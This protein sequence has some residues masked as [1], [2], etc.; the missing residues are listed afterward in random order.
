[1]IGEA[2]CR[3]EQIKRVEALLQEQFSREQA[4]ILDVARKSVSTADRSERSC[5]QLAER[6]GER[7]TELQKQ[8]EALQ[9]QLSDLRARIEELG[10]EG[11]EAV[12]GEAEA[13]ARHISRVENICAELSAKFPER[14]AEIQKLCALVGALQESSSALHTQLDGV[15]SDPEAKTSESVRELQE[16]IDAHWTEWVAE[17]TKQEDALREEVRARKA[18]GQRIEQLRADLA[19]RLSESERAVAADDQRV[20]VGELQSRVAELQM[21]LQGLSEQLGASVDS[22]E[23][24]LH[25]MAQA[26]AEHGEHVGAV[27]ANLSAKAEACESNIERL[28][29]VV[30]EMQGQVEDLTSQL[31]V[32]P[33][34]IEELANSSKEGLLGE[35]R[36]RV[37]FIRRAEMTHAQLSA[38]ADKCDNDVAGVHSLVGELQGHVE[39]LRAQFVDIPPRWDVFAD[40]SRKALQGEAQ[41]RSDDVHRIEEAAHKEV[42]AREELRQRMEEA[43]TWLSDKYSEC[44]VELQAQLRDLRGQVEA[45]T[46]SS[47]EALRGVFEVRAENARHTDAISAQLHGKA[48]DRDENAERL[49]FI[50]EELQRNVEH[51]QV[52]LEAL[53]PRIDESANKSLEAVIGEAQCR[54][55]QI[56]RV[57][58]LLQE[59]FS[60]EQADI[61]DVARKSVSTADR[62]ERSCAQLA[63]R[64]GE[65]TTELQKQVEALQTQL[66]DLR[67]RIEELGME[68]EEAVR[69]EAEARARHISRVENICAELSA[70]FPERDAEIQKL[71]ALVGALQESSSALHTQLDGV[72]SD[73]EAKTSESVRELQE[74]ID[75]HWTEWVAECTKQEDAL[76]E[77]VRARKAEG[78]RMEEAC[79]WLSEKCS[80][81]VVELQ[82]QLHD[83]KGQVEATTCSIEE[84]LR[85]VSEA[86]AEHARHADAIS[87]QLRGQADDRDNSAER[88]KLLVAELQGNVEDLQVQLEALSPQIDEF[89][90]KSE[91][92]VTGEAQC[93]AEQIQR[94]EALLQ[95][96]SQSCIGVEEKCTQLGVRGEECT[97]QIDFLRSLVH[98]L[99]VRVETHEAQSAAMGS[100]LEAQSCHDEVNAVTSLV[101]E[102]RAKVDVLQAQSTA[103]LPEIEELINK[104]DQALQLESRSRIEDIQRLEAM[105]AQFRARGPEYDASKSHA[106]GT[107][108][109]EFEG[110]D[111][112]DDVGS[113]RGVLC[114][115]QTRLQEDHDMADAKRSQ[116]EMAIQATRDMCLGRIASCERQQSQA[117]CEKLEIEVAPIRAE[118]SDMRIGFDTLRGHIDSLRR[119]LEGPGS[120]HDCGSERTRLEVAR[121]ELDE[122]IRG[123][124]EAKQA[125]MR[126]HYD[127]L[128]H[129]VESLRQLVSDVRLQ[130][131]GLQG[132]V[133]V[134]AGDLNRIQDTCVQVQVDHDTGQGETTLLHPLLAQL[135]GHI[136]T[137]QEKVT[138]LPLQFEVT[139]QEMEESLQADVRACLEEARAHTEDIDRVEQLCARLQAKDPERTKEA[140]LLRKGVFEL[141]EQ[142]ATLKVE[143]ESLASQ[144]KGTCAEAPPSVDD[145][146][147]AQQLFEKFKGFEAECRADVESQLLAVNELQARIEVLQA[148]MLAECSPEGHGARRADKLAEQTQGIEQTCAQLE[149]AFLEHRGQTD[150]LQ[151]LVERLEGR[152][153]ALSVQSYPAELASRIDMLQ[154]TLLAKNHADTPLPH[155]LLDDVLQNAQRLQNQFEEMQLRLG[156][157]QVSVEEEKAS[158]QALAAVD[159]G[160]REEIESLR[161]SFNEI[162]VKIEAWETWVQ[163]GNMV[164]RDAAFQSDRSLSDEILLLWSSMSDLQKRLVTMETQT[165]AVREQLKETIREEADLSGQKDEDMQRRLNDL[166]A[167]VVALVEEHSDDVVAIA[168]QAAQSAADRAAAKLGGTRVDHLEQFNGVLCNRLNELRAEF[169]AAL[170]DE[171]VRNSERAQRMVH[172]LGRETVEKTTSHAISQACAE[173]RAMLSGEMEIY[174]RDLEGHA[175]RLKILE[176]GD[177]KVR[178][179]TS[180]NLN[181]SAFDAEAVRSQLAEAMRDKDRKMRICAGLAVVRDEV[182]GQV[183]GSGDIPRCPKLLDDERGGS[184]CANAVATEVRPAQQGAP[185]PKGPR[186]PTGPRHANVIQAPTGTVGN[187]STVKTSSSVARFVSR[188]A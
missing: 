176:L 99:Q 31:E 48:D 183:T 36:S 86:R 164:G 185:Q 87:A 12:R 153:E 162:L 47:E 30:A 49:K 187:G 157:C 72:R 7:T 64:L 4:D 168:E 112:I 83:L 159:A 170:D 143:V 169:C 128:H 131:E 163:G 184:A 42:Q 121:S 126:D 19:G 76:R 71:C 37:E 22:N 145:G 113:L 96:Q 141:Q 93:R 69:G 41:A 158:R 138:T 74:R 29:L 134:F 6:L 91:E 114:E 62:S 81:C 135:H 85:G 117:V 52:Q 105:C 18:E 100:Q 119:R 17:R 108:R 5:A 147:L 54:A 178:E 144:S 80:E 92:A 68:G 137:L 79:T 34:R 180:T 148:Q 107:A 154:E 133:R 67:A 97:S 46:R 84:A 78:Q 116:L 103:R 136:Q 165:E 57:E 75:A 188:P 9:T 50:V 125:E 109:F 73:P 160:H 98:Q 25:G 61:L 102:L 55:E 28:R 152:F 65:R 14:D 56:K 177:Q 15:R 44:V 35:A 186:P 140:K 172:E 20:I 10:M 151:L 174:R 139:F 89:G 27:H 142:T 173:V 24:A 111:D 11:E 132:E 146:Q 16:R 130:M 40:E 26:H 120:L 101:A 70:K 1:V 106:L 38:K 3:A 21:Q 179:A 90:N 166:E 58:A 110:E 59:Q 118:F 66:S 149:A 123:R 95:Q 182:M 175:E 127:R 39:M 94:V 63:E 2:Q 181:N 60:R 129:E 122:T 171:K 8:V 115:L 32:I 156:V 104:S 23:Q 88:L 77:E 150:S 45:T 51:L 43:S 82:A 161:K 124:E 13:R 167:Q 33:P 155:P 53:S